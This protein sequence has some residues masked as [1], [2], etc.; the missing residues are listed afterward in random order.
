M[1]MRERERE[2]EKEREGERKSVYLFVRTIRRT[3]TMIRTTKRMSTTATTIGRKEA[4][5]ETLFDAWENY[6]I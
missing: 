1:K 4:L 6:N 2:R 3:T 5:I